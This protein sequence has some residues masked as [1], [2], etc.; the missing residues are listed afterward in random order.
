MTKTRDL[1][2]LGGGFIQAG[3]GAVQRTV[4]SKLQDMV[5]VKDFGAVGDGVTD[6]TAAIQAALTATQSNLGGTV[7]IP[8]GEYRVTSTLTAGNGVQLIGL[9]T[10]FS[11]K[12]RVK[13]DFTGNE[14]LSVVNGSSLAKGVQIKN[15]RVQ[16]LTAP[17][18]TDGIVLYSA[19]DRC[20]LENVIVDGMSPDGRGIV[21]TNNPLYT[22]FKVS[23]DISL[24]NC[25]VFKAD[26]TAGTGIGHCFDFYRC[27]EFS[28][29]N[30][31]ANGNNGSPTINAG[32]NFVNCYGGTL[33]NPHAHGNKYGIKIEETETPEGQGGD[34]TWN[35]GITILGPTYES[36][37]GAGAYSLYI[38]GTA[39]RTASKVWQENPRYVDGASFEIS[40]TYLEYARWCHIDCGKT[41]RTPALEIGP[42]VQDCTFKPL[43]LSK[44]SGD[45][46][47]NIIIL[48]SPLSER[49]AWNFNGYGC[50]L[51]K[52]ENQT[53]AS[54][55][56]NPVTWGAVRKDA[57]SFY[58][59]V[60]DNTRI[61]VPTGLDGAYL[62]QASVAFAADATGIREAQLYVNG[63]A[64]P[65][66]RT[67]IN[68]SGA[69]SITVVNI[70][71]TYQLSG[72]DYIQVYAN[73]NNGSTLA[74]QNASCCISFHKIGS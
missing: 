69:G 11:T 31:R 30:C 50:I 32:F 54:A 51:N 58:D 14:V 33:V 10:E 45:W 24:R 19:Y 44:V 70:N 1:A 18:G 25:Q 66:V 39:T 35:S 5:S 8:P 60:T 47:D 71:T 17:D 53:L 68:N 12:I 72:G 16:M 36:T 41:N 74:L 62:I 21:F 22:T 52:D 38:S 2:D 42:F 37:N 46:T 57:Y 29:E 13:S 61:T 15:L 3:T 23:Q 27:N 49:P 6:D 34:Y 73:H 26:G 43:A 64:R 9:G 63:F 20:V 7:I 4:E 55:V 65:E 56:A 48:D 40:K 28:L 67:V 59:E